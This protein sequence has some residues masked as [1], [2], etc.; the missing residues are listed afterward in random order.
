MP[1]ECNKAACS[2]I[3]LETKSHLDDCAESHTSR[4]KE[5]VCDQILVQ[6]TCLHFQQS[7][8]LHSGRGNARSDLTPSVISKHPDNRPAFDFTGVNE[9]FEKR[10]TTQQKW[11][12]FL[13]LP[14]IFIP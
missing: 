8:T 7:A 11:V 1:S 14:H 9:V 13:Y 4:S 12:E 3:G 6:K 10:S 5:Q 2:N